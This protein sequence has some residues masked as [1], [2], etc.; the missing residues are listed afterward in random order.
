MA[1]MVVPPRERLTLKSAAVSPATGELLAPAT[2]TRVMKVRG[3]AAVPT[4]SKAE[5]V[6]LLMVIV[7]VTHATLT[8]T[9]PPV[10]IA[11]TTPAIRL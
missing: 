9:D 8:F 10:S 1:G 7:G 2:R 11:L 3:A 6:G 5:V 4:I